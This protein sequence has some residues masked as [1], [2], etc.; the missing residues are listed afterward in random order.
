HD[1]DTGKSGIVEGS[2]MASATEAIQTIN[3]HRVHLRHVF[4]GRSF[5]V[6]SKLPGGAIHFAAIE[7]FP[8]ALLFIFIGRSGF[9]KDAEGAIIYDAIDAFDVADHVVVHYA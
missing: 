4:S 1:A 5:N 7:S 9:G 2:V 3:Q 8:N 6:S